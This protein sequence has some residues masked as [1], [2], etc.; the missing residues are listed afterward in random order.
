[1]AKIKYDVSNVEDIADRTQAPVGLYR[2]KVVKAEAKKSAKDNQMIEVQ[3]R[4][5][6]DGA[7]KKLK[8]EYGDVWDYPIIDHDHPF[9]KARFKEF[10]GAFGLKSKG[11]LD[12]DKLVGKSVQVKLKSDTDQDGEYRPRVGKLMSLAQEEAPEEEVEESDTEEEDDDEEGIDLNDLSRAELKK[13]IKEEELEIKVLKSHS[14]DDIREAIAEAMGIEDEPEEEDEPEDDEEEEEEDADEEESEDEEEEGDN[15][16]ELSV[17]DLK[18][19][20][21]ERELKTNGAKK[22][23]IARLRKDDGDDSF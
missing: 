21:S 12:T 11:D 17:A 13:L 4:L 7:G 3:Y 5:T 16:D 19:E 10:I 20:L 6:H 18:A 23:L 1:M 14:D 15:Y 22:V 9:V 8:E 2:A